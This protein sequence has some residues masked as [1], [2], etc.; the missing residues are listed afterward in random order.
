MRVGIA[1]AGFMARTHA[2]EYAGMGVEVAAVASRSGPQGFID[3]L[4]LDATAHT[5]VAT[6][7]KRTDIDY[8]DVCTPTHTH[9]DL[10]RTAAEAGV[11]VFVEKPVAGTLGEAHK[12]AD[13]VDEADLTFMV[14]HVVRF[15][16]A[17]RAAKDLEIGSHGVARARRLSPFPDWGSD[18]WFADREK[19]GGIFVDLGIH[20]LD[21]L[22]WCWGEVDR[23]FARRRRD[24]SAE[25]G[26][27]TLRF[28]S[29]AV[30][31]V[32]SSWSQPDSRPFTT[33]LEFAGDD[34]LVELSSADESPYREWADDAVVERPVAKN[35]YR[36][37][38]EHFI[39]CLE[40]GTEP[41]VGVADATESLRLALAAERS[42][43]RGEPVR[44][45]EVVA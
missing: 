12:I 37:E 17:Y 27:V 35:A 20:D 41:E 31:Y 45:E 15:D 43:E 8:L 3:E 24:A 44:P 13:I 14:G 34:G 33:E 38:L 40:S 9:L 39:A 21:Y 10:V 2:E 4:G 28:E 25:H 5:D 11:D 42:A 29:G 22:R 6:L 26:F 19:S 32:E 1:G 7:C 30:G 36:R 23:V 18:D 16:Q